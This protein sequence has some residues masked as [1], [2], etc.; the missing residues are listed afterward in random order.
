LVAG[1]TRNGVTVISWLARCNLMIFEDCICLAQARVIAGRKREP[2]ICT[3]AFHEPTESFLRFCLPFQLDRT[4][5]VKRWQRFTFEGDKERLTNDN[6]RETWHYGS[7]LGRSATVSQ[8]EQTELHGKILRQYQYEHELNEDRSSIGV[9]IPM[10]GFKLVQ[11]H[12]SPNEASDAKELERCKL[13]AE[14][15]IWYPDFKVKAKGHRMV[16]GVKKSFEKT[17]VAWDVYE[18]IRT[19]RSNPFQ[20]IYG[21]RNPYFIIGNLATKRN[22]F[23]V[24]GVLSAPNNAIQRNAI[25]QQ[26]SLLTCC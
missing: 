19:G 15:G 10:C 1:V 22:A 4:P 14:K 26:M 21:Y 3:I 8:R 12:L 11:E 13:M 9:L 20:S 5:A 25:H 24:V 16:D 17:V 23:I 7:V 6:R 2:H 18:A